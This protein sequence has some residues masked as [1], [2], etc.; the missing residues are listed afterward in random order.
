ML[1]IFV[2]DA[3]GDK[4]NF[5]PSHI[6]ASKARVET[7]GVRGGFVEHLSRTWAAQQSVTKI[8]SLIFINLA[9]PKVRAKHELLFHEPASLKILN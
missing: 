1:I 7:L 3:L 5:Q 8:K 6:S 2:T 4:R 9:T